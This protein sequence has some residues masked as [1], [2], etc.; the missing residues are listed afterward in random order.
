MA[1]TR[2]EYASDAVAF[3]RALRIAQRHHRPPNARVD[4]AVDQQGHQREY[5]QGDVIE[6]DIAD[7]HA[8]DPIGRQLDA[9]A[10]FE[11]IDIIDYGA[12]EECESQRP[13]GH[14]CARQ[15]QEDKRQDAPN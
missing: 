12:D 13:D 4:Q 14:E 11:Q 9:L 1:A 15:P 8:K 5:D 3:R 7:D 2:I 10:A 6:A